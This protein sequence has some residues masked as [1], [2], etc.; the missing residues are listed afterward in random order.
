MQH[1]QRG[2]YRQKV[3]FWSW[4]K[5]DLCVIMLFEAKAKRI[6]K[7]PFLKRLYKEGVI[8]IVNYKALKSFS[9]NCFFFRLQVLHF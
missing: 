5:C 1:H 9:K 2:L 6:L 7:A 8:G 3:H 4:E